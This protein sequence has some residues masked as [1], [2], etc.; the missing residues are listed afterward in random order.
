MPS[1]KAEQIIKILR[2]EILSGKR[3]PGEK[4]PTY[5]A[6][7]EQFRVTRPTVARVLDGLRTQ[8]PPKA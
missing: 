4:L 2:D 3:T 7:M 5:D 1:R 8:Y 6:L